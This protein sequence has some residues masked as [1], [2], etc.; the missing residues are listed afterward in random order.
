[1]RIFLFFFSQEQDMFTTLILWYTIHTKKNSILK[2]NVQP[3]ALSQDNR[4]AE[5]LKTDDREEVKNMCDVAERLEQRGIK[6]GVE[7]GVEKGIKSVAINLIRMGKDNS[8][9]MQ[10]T[11]LSEATVENLRKSIRN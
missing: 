4:Y 5:I 1:M 9:I 10:A 11:N 8:L 6:H 7:Q 3:P 2:D